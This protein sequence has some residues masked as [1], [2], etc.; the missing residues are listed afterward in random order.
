MKK[1]TNI[2][3]ILIVCLFVTAFFWGGGSA[4]SVG[5]MQDSLQINDSTRYFDFGEATT[6]FILTIQDSSNSKVDSLKAYIRGGTQTAVG[7]MN[8]QVAFH[9][10]SQT[11]STTDIA[12]LIPGDGVTSTYKFH[13]ETPVFGVFVVRVNVGGVTGAVGYPYKTPV[14]VRYNK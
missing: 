5:N 13:S 3:P 1:L 8:S 12:L 7:L 10:M 9:E 11:T 4:P 6:D 14:A 2:I